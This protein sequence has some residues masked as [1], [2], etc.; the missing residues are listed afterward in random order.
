MKLINQLQGFES[1]ITHDSVKCPSELYKKEKNN[2][3]PTTGFLTLHQ[4]ECIRELTHRHKMKLTRQI[5]VFKV[6]ENYF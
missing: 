6:E 4:T 3:E 1:L 5:S 2:K